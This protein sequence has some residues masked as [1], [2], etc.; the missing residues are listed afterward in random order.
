[1]SFLVHAFLVLLIG[2]GMLLGA[3]GVAYLV[4]RR[5][6]RRRWRSLRGHGATRGVLATASVV[7]GW[8]ERA[9]GLA[10]PR[11][12]TRSTAAGT[13]RAMWVAVGDAERAVQHGQEVDAPLAELPAI[14]HR[15]RGMADELDHLLRLERRLPGG[16]QGRPVSV[17][18]QAAE[19]IHAARDVQ[20]AA[21]Q[22]SSD[23]SDPHLRSVVRD[24]HDE[25]EILAAALTRMRSAS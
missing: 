13:R 12:V 6:V 23:S 15:L 20:L 7:A 25:V 10:P 9:R 17:R 1:V 8:H 22:A 14:C 16:A 24:A 4:I 21:L 11:D 2:G 18:N 19:L 5:Q 3:I